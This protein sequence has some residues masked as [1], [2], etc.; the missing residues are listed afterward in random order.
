MPETLSTN[1]AKL[2][3]YFQDVRHFQ[4]IRKELLGLFALP[5]AEE[6]QVT[7]IYQTYKQPGVSLVAVHIRRGDYLENTAVNHI[8]LDYYVEA[9]RRMEKVLRGPKVYLVFSDD[10]AWCQQVL[11]VTFPQST[12]LYSSGHSEVT[13]LMLMSRA[14]AYIIANSSYSWFGWYLNP[15]AYRVHVIA[16]RQWFRSSPGTIQVKDHFILV[17]P[18]TRNPHVPCRVL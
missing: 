1:E 8:T 11:P 10:L 18:Q 17:G 13:D 5:A 9:F 3:G 2:Q 16:P 15:R 4:A 14:D 7:T 6:K 12:F